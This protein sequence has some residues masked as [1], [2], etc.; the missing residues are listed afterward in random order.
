MK[1]SL[2]QKILSIIDF[3]S[4]RYWRLGKLY[5]TDFDRTEKIEE[6]LDK[7]PLL[8]K[9]LTS[10]KAKLATSEKIVSVKLKGGLGNQLYEIAAV[11]G[12]A[13]GHNIKPVFKKIKSSPTRVKTRPVYWDT[14]FQKLP[15]VKQ[16]PYN[17]FLYQQ[18]E[19]GFHV[20]PKPNEICN[21]NNYSGI[22]FNG[23]FASEKYFDKFREKL[24]PILFYINP[25]EKEYLE[26][27]YPAIFNEESI[28]I[29]L[30]IRRGDNITHPKKVAQPPLWESD[31]YH[32]AIAYF[33][34][35]FGT[36]K[37]KIYM[38]CTDQEFVKNYMEKEYP[39]LDFI[40]PNEKD[41]LEMFLMSSC[42]HNIIANSTFSWWAAYMNN[43][44]DRIV[45][46]PKTWFFKSEIHKNWDYRY[47]DDWLR[48]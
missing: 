33:K 48:F 45:I 31:Y 15:L 1:E 22:I 42:N 17:L 44:P 29:S 27:K 40:F 14:A 10:L 20:I 6:F 7:I 41:Y 12:Y 35:K 26:K 37:L 46:A 23:H 11:L 34:E 13:W 19:R 16:R 18:G 5:K 2:K 28:A 39:N 36:D 30:H 8:G 32:K 43:N 24:L 4:D 21:L 25:S 9:S 47:L 3:I 38:F